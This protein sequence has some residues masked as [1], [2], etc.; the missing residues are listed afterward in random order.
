MRISGRHLRTFVLASLFGLGCA[1]A[2]TPADDGVT[3]D[4]GAA[5][6]AS[7][8]AELQALLDQ[9]GETNITA[10]Q[11]DEIL[12]AVVRG[13]MSSDRLKAANDFHAAGMKRNQGDTTGYMR[14]G[15]QMEVLCW[16]MPRD[17]AASGSG[18]TG[19]GFGATVKAVADDDDPSPYSVRVFDTARRDYTL[20]WKL[21]G[22][23]LS[24]DV[25]EGTS[26][27]DLATQIA[28][29]IKDAGDS[30]RLQENQECAGVP[31]NGDFDDLLGIHSADVTEDDRG[32]KITITP[33]FD[34]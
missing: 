16:A 5:D 7:R 22:L 34:A 9:M 28:A 11:A 19:Q 1:G 29:A 3:A 21:A 26:A 27:K 13:G 31:N 33:D 32:A 10:D 18:R 4:P 12:F 30:G 2:S 24:V 6:Q 15:T 20:S 14:G 8:M 25:A 17:F 23:D